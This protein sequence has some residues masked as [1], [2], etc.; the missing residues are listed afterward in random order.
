M[1]PASSSTGAWAHLN[2]AEPSTRCRQPVTGA[3][4][5]F[6]FLMRTLDNKLLAC[7]GH[8]GAWRVASGHTHSNSLRFGYGAVSASTQDNWLLTFS[9]E[10]VFISEKYLQTISPAGDSQRSNKQLTRECYLR[11]FSFVCFALCTTAA[12]HMGINYLT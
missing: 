11:L 5:K 7:R 12:M 10:L 8:R 6:S 4:V 9:G 1:S 2:L 3:C